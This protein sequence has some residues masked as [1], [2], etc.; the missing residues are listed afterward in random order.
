MLNL[1]LCL[2]LWTLGCLSMGV[3]GIFRMRGQASRT[4]LGHALGLLAFLL[5]MAGMV[6]ATRYRPDGL[7]PQGVAAGLLLAG[8]LWEHPSASIADQT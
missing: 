1:E 8:M 6:V 7:A 3:A 2:W 4:T 5:L